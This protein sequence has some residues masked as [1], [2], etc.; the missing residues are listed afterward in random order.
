MASSGKQNA[1]GHMSTG[2]MVELALCP[3]LACDICIEGKRGVIRLICR[4]YR[5]Q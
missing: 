1:L 2:L 4:Q 3:P 5:A